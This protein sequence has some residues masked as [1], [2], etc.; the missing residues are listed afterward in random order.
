MKLLWTLRFLRAGVKSAKSRI[1]RIGRRFA[2][3]H[4]SCWTDFS[5]RDGSGR[6][7]GGLDPTGCQAPGLFPQ[8]LAPDFVLPKPNRHP[9]LDPGSTFFSIPVEEQGGCR[10]KSGMTGGGA[11]SRASR[12]SREIR[13]IGEKAAASGI[14]L[15][16]ACR[17]FERPSGLRRGGA[18]ASP[19]PPRPPARPPWL[20]DA[21]VAPGRKRRRT[22]GGSRRY[23]CPPRHACYI[24]A[25]PAA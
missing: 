11:P 2:A 12:P 18:L 10:I 23:P 9:G 22:Q 8:Y 24:P 3:L 20:C 4:P 17:D 16:S 7:H 19:R 1:A 15:Q 5:I 21:L 14:V 6:A 13:S 25:R